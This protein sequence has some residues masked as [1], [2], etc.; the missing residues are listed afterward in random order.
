VRDA[1]QALA[2]EAVGVKV[3][4]L[5]VGPVSLSDVQ[6]ASATGAHIVAFNVKSAGFEVDAQAKQLQVGILPHRVIYR[7]LDEVSTI[8]DRGSIKELPHGQ[9]QGGLMLLLSG[10]PA[11]LG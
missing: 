11:P 2:S 6:Q 7:L 3:V 5:G 10:I 1:V 4:S 8:C 9:R